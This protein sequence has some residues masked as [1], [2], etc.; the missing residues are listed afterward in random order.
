MQRH[1]LICLVLIL[2]VVL[3]GS[4]T[5][6]AAQTETP[7]MG[8]FDTLMMD[9]MMVSDQR[10]MESLLKITMAADDAYMEMHNGEAIAFLVAFDVEVAAQSFEHP[11]VISESTAKQLIGEADA[12]VDLLAMPAT[13]RN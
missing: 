8:A 12:L 9:V 1:L 13:P 10:I 2:G 4:F 11:K 6:L 7:I 3:T 5:P